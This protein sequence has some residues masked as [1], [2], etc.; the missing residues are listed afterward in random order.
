MLIFFANKLKRETEISHQHSWTQ[1]CLHSFLPLQVEEFF[2]KMAAQ[3]ESTERVYNQNEEREAQTSPTQSEGK[4]EQEILQAEG[5]F[6]QLLSHMTHLYNKS[7]TLVKKMQQRFGHSF[8]AAFTTELRPSP[9][10]GMQD[11]PTGFFTAAGLDHILDS[12]YDL[13][14]NVLEE[15]SSTVTDVFEEI[16]EAEEY[17]QQSSRGVWCYLKHYLL[18]SPLPSCLCVK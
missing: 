3:L 8:F 12:V 6:G 2:R 1:I 9:L 16:Q 17:F 5:S 4:A 13:G 15:F 7:V 11:G 10:S 18:N 14:R